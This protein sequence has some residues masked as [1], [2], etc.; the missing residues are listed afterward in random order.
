MPILVENAFSMR[1]RVA[2]LASFSF[3]ESYWLAG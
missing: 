1:G 3:Y 2:L